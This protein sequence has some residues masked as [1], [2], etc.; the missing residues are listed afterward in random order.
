[1]AKTSK[2]LTKYQNDFDALKD[3]RD[4]WDKREQFVIGEIYDSVSQTTTRS[5]VV[6]Q[7]LLSAMI[8]R[9]N[10][11]MAKLPTGLV[12]VMSKKNKGKSVILNAI[13]NHYII[14]NADTQYDIYTKFWMAEFASLLYGK[15]DLLVDYV[16]KGDY[17]GPDFYVI[18]VRNGIPEAGNISVNDCN[19]YWVRSWVSKEW[20]GGRKKLDGWKGIDGALEKVKKGAKV[21]D[22]DKTSYIE[23]KYQSELQ[24]TKKIEL[25][26][27]YEKD[28]WTTF[29][30][31]ADVVL[32]EI[33]NPHKNSE[34]PIVS[35]VNI[36]LI[37]RYQG[38]SEY[39]RF[40][41]QQ[42]HQTHSLT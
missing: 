34:L 42:K 13:L 26:T 22:N 21:S 27:L 17:V 31:A 11:V 39:E 25:L 14:P 16:V 18:P 2:L 6:D 30:P 1:M 40:I 36:P 4:T 41:S 7:T 33:D 23:R 19:H 20:L 28:K 35:K 10:D 24:R 12:R 32:R 37:D 29:S 9:T 38:L 8:R 5:Q 3:V 15:Q